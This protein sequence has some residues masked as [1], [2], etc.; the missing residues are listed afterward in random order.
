VINLQALVSSE[1]PPH[2]QSKPEKYEKP[3][4]L[5]QDAF[6][7]DPAILVTRCFRSTHTPHRHGFSRASQG[8][9]H[10]VKASPQSHFDSSVKENPHLYSGTTI[11]Y[12]VFFVVGMSIRVFFEIQRGDKV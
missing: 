10:K 6:E 7:C 9:S 2:E 3:P 8:R 12:I 11:P 4:R 5:K 1:G